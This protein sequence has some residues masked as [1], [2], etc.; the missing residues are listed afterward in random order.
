MGGIWITDS[1]SADPVFTIAW[2]GW[3]I[4][5]ITLHELAHGWAAI[6]RGDRTPIEM[7]RMTFNPVVHMGMMSLLMLALLGIAWGVMPVNPSRMRGRHADAFVAA[8]GPAMNIALAI[9]SIL[10]YVAWNVMMNSSLGSSIP[11]HVQDNA[12][13]VFHAGALLNVVLA[14]FNMLPIPPLDGSHIAADFFP[15]YARLLSGPQG[16]YLG[17]GLFIAVWLFGGSALF[18]LAGRIVNFT[19]HVLMIPFV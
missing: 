19:A 1:W 12:M 4:V 2:V 7:G 3:L 14:L 9:L 6:S 11:A 10:L 18:G 17:L 13:M 8:A 16:Q 15:G 5:S